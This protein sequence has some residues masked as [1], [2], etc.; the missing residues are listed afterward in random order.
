MCLIC[1][2]IT[3]TIVVLQ[4]LRESS[5]ETDGPTGTTGLTFAKFQQ[6]VAPSDFQAKLRLNF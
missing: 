6:I 1:N 5:G 2:R 4:I 3:I